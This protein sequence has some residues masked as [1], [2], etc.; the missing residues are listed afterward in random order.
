MY[1]CAPQGCEEFRSHALPLRHCQHSR[2][3]H[4]DVTSL[5][6]CGLD[7]QSML[8]SLQENKVTVTGSQGLIMKTLLDVAS[9]T[10]REGW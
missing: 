3:I 6:G 2:M 1:R 10:G 5:P 7:H 4:L 8:M 9:G